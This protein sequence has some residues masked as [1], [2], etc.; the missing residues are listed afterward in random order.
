LLKLCKG[1]TTPASQSPTP[2]RSPPVPYSKA[3]DVETEPLPSRSQG[4][5]PKRPWQSVK[6]GVE[7]LGEAAWRRVDVRDGAKGPLVVDM[8]KR[9]G[10]S[11]THRRQQSDAEL[12]VVI[13]SRDRDQAQMVKGEMTCPPPPWGHRCR[14]WPGWLQP[15]SVS[16][17]ASSAARAKPVWPTTRCAIGLAGSSIKRF[18]YWLR[19]SWRGKPSGGKMAAGNLPDRKFARALR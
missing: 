15:P 14:S 12:W 16:K 6:Q 18:R 10:V 3:A 7:S 1:P 9:R 19:G 2:P 4:R 8:V 13:R 5:P 11:R 17:H